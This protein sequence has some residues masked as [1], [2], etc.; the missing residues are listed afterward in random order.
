MPSKRK[1]EAY[2]KRLAKISA[3]DNPGRHLTSDCLYAVVTYCDLE[4]QEHRQGTLVGFGQRV[5]GGLFGPR[6]ATDITVCTACVHQSGGNRCDDSEI[7]VRDVAVLEVRRNGDG[8]SSREA[9]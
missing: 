2:R 4:D 1:I 7:S 3:K 9:S 6:V 5:A 8:H